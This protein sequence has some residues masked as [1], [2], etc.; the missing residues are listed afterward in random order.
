MPAR[1]SALAAVDTSDEARG[2]EVVRER[3]DVGDHLGGVVPHRRVIDDDVG[4][5]GVLARDAV[6]KRIGSRLAE[7]ETHRPTIALALLVIDDQLDIAVGGRVRRAI[8]SNANP[9]NRGG[10][11]GD[12]DR[13]W[14]SEQGSAP[15]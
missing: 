11:G 5:H 6:Q 13:L 10:D 7:V 15:V 1:A 2:R 14:I 8:A 3:L 4:T 9:G 12:G